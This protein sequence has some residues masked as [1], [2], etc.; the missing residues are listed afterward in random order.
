MKKVYK[1]PCMKT[2]MLDK[3]SIL[4]GSPEYQS[5]DRSFM[6]GSD[7]DLDDVYHTSD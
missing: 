3:Q 5:L 2:I 1:E 7:A 6:G 4:S